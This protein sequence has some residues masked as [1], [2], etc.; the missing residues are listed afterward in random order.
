MLPLLVFCFV[1]PCHCYRTP[2]TSDES[3]IDTI[4]VPSMQGQ[5]VTITC[6]T[7]NTL[8]CCTRGL[9]RGKG[10]K[11]LIP[12]NCQDC[13]DSF[14]VTHNISNNINILQIS[15]ISKSDVGIYICQCDVYQN[16][17]GCSSSNGR[18][19]FGCYNVTIPDCQLQYE[20]NGV[21]TNLYGSSG[22]RSK[23]VV[24][25]RENDTIS[26]H[27]VVGSDK[28]DCSKMKKESSITVERSHNGRKFRCKC[29]KDNVTCNIVIVLNVTSN[30]TSTSIAIPVTTND[31][32][33][34][35]KTFD[36]TSTRKPKTN[37]LTAVT[38]S[39]EASSLTSTNGLSSVSSHVLIDNSSKPILHTVDGSSVSE[40]FA[41]AVSTTMNKVRSFPSTSN[42][43][44][45]ISRSNDEFHHERTSNEL[46]TTSKASD[47]ST[48]TPTGT[49]MVSISTQ[50]YFPANDIYVIILSCF[51]VG[52]GAVVILLCLGIFLCRARRQCIQ[53]HNDKTEEWVNPIYESSDNKIQLKAA[54]NR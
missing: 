26:V 4:H 31:V 7:S 17:E 36:W 6:N 13:G 45:I 9:W 41:S 43:A 10:K 38:N 15:N 28:T 27:C 23:A 46:S 30:R 52:L 19:N 21:R 20:V 5:N 2:V 1:L 39:I 37:I 3:C 34:N 11:W 8:D 54:P 33:I 51:I 25:V 22:T 44:N 48:V 24:D 16:M 32:I 47:S 29:S 14:S 50:S 53:V 42:S 35:N 49:Q 40:G 12:D 18:M